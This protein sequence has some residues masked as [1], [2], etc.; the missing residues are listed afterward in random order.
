MGWRCVEV[1]CAIFVSAVHAGLNPEMHRTI[2]HQDGPTHG[3]GG[4]D[5]AMLRT[6]PQSPWATVP[7]VTN[8][9]AL[10]GNLL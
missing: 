10:N 5:G 2:V 3:E 8:L 4:R 9:V 7:D 1:V 6:L